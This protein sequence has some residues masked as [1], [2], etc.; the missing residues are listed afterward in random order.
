MS[1]LAF[2]FILTTMAISGRTQQ[3]GGESPPPE[4]KSLKTEYDFIV[5]GGGTAGC[6]V[7]ARLSER[8]DWNVLVLEAGDNESA[9]VDVPI[10]A[11]YAVLSRF[12]WPYL[13]R[14]DDRFCRG[15]EGGSC[16]WVR[17]K[18]LGGSSVINYMI[19]SRGAARDYDAW[20]DSGLKGWSYKDVLP[21][22]KK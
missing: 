17:G 20:A 12:T 2:L 18:A 15:M 13:A 11:S 9:G 14:K 16:R 22:F 7:A 6:V 5:V 19:Y 10:L 21:Y 1:T 8:P 3:F 4:P